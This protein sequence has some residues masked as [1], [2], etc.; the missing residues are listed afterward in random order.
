MY[1]LSSTD[2]LAILIAL[3]GACG[4]IVFSMIRTYRLEKQNHDLRKVIKILQ[5]EKKR[6]K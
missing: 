4:L 1:Q 3:I 2:L 5:M 6:G